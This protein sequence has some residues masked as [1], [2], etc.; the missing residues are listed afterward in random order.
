M[1]METSYYY[2][3]EVLSF[4]TGLRRGH[5]Q[6]RRERRLS[7]PFLDNMAAVWGF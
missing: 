3:S 2:T 4:L 6:N 7:L 1:V 5:H